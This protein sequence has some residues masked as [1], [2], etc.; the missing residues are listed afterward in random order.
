VSSV[1]IG[2]RVARDGALVD[3][4]P[5]FDHPA[6]ARATIRI[7]RPIGP[8]DLVLAAP[9]G[10]STADA[11]VVEF[12]GP[13][14]MR[15]ATLPVVDGVVAPDGEGTVARMAVV[16][17]YSGA[18]ATGCCFIGGLGV[19]ARSPRRSTRLHNIVGTAMTPP[20]WR[21]PPTLSRRAVATA[22]WQAGG[23]PL[24]LPIAGLLSDRPWPRWRTISRR[25]SAARRRLGCTPP[26]RPVYAL[27]SCA[28]EP[29]VGVTDR[30]S[31]RP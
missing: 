16:E 8:S 19:G 1:V 17:R 5:T 23:A 3:E 30:E 14:T 6:W 10:G 31:S 4:P 28:A 9:T 7:S 27:N 26:Y 25:S 18:G 12:G 20:T 2:D 24:A 22:P 11:V 29:L 21:S 13:K 15:V